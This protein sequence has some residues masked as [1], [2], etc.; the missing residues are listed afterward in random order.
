MPVRLQCPNPDCQASFSVLEGDAPR[1][2]RCPQCGWEL[3]GLGT[4]EPNL[5]GSADSPRS[6]SNARAFAGLTAGSTFAVRYEIVKQL[7]RGGMGVVYL[8]KDT[9][10]DREVALKIPFVWDDEDPEFLQRFNREARAAARLHHPNICPIFDVG[11]HDGQPYL[12]MAYL[13]GVL[14]SSYIKQR[15]GPLEPRDAIRLVRKLAKALSAAHQKGVIHRDLKPSNIMIDREIGPI[16]MDFGLARREDLEETLRTRAGH[17]LGTPAYMPIEQFQGKIEAVGPRSDVYSL[18]VILF[19]LLTGR[20]PYEG[21]AFEIHV[22][23]LRTGPPSPS[24]FRTEL[25]PGLDAVCLKAMAREPEDRYAS[26]AEF[27]VALVGAMQMGRS[28]SASSVKDGLDP[29]GELDAA[30]NALTPHR[31]EQGSSPQN[32]IL[33]TLPEPSI[34][35]GDEP[36]SSEP[37]A[38][39]P[40]RAAEPLSVDRD[41]VWIPSTRPAEPLSVDRD[42]VWVPTG[43]QPT[44]VLP[45]IL[46]RFKLRHAVGLGIVVALFSFVASV[47]YMTPGQNLPPGVSIP[48]RRP[49]QSDPA[50]RIGPQAKSVA[51]DQDIVRSRLRQGE[52]YLK[53]GQYDRALGEFDAVARLDPKSA[54][55][56][57]N[58]GIARTALNDYSHAMVDF[59]EAIRLDPKLAPAYASRGRVHLAYAHPDEA[60]AD[61]EQAQKLDSTVSV[62]DDVILVPAYIKRGNVFLG[63]R[64]WDLAIAAFDRATALS[65]ND[66]RVE[67]GRGQAY[68]SQ[69]ADA[70]A[71]RGE[72]SGLQGRLRPAIADFSEALSLQP[73][74]LKALNGRGLANYYVGEFDLAITDANAALSTKPDCVEALLVRAASRQEKGRVDQAI[75]DCGRAL[76]LQPRSLLARLVRREAHRSKG[77]LDK[78][79]ADAEDSLSLDPQTLVEL[80]YRSLCLATRNEVDRALGDIDK[81]LQICPDYVVALGNRADFYRIKGDLE[82]AVLDAEKAIKL[83]PS[84]PRL[85]LIRGQIRRAKGEIAQAI[86]DEEKAQSIYNASG[87]RSLSESGRAHNEKG[88]YDRAVKVLDEAIRID[89][90]YATAYN[91]R[92]NAYFGK[93][94]FASAISD[95]SEAIR[96]N[97]T[98]AV[99]YRNRGEA[100]HET[101]TYDR[102]IADFGQAIKLDP[103]DARAYYGRGAAYYSKQDYDLAIA[104]FDNAIR[105]DP[106]YVSAHNV[107]GNSFD[108]RKDYPR[109]IADYTQAIKLKPGDAVLY[110]NR[111]DTYVKMEKFDLA[112]ADSDEAIRL[113]PKFALAYNDRG[114]AYEAKK[115]YD[116]AI[117]AR[118][119]AIQLMPQNAL[120][121]RNRGE[122]YFRAGRNPE[123]LDDAEEAIR[124][125]PKHALAYNLRGV[126]YYDKSDFARAIADYDQAINLMPGHA[127]LYRNRGAAYEKMGN[128]EAAKADFAEADRLEHK[129]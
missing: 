110:R 52:N 10:L 92:G 106:K 51:V 54:A 104:D 100:Y 9:R 16:L 3:S 114:N 45:A 63:Q 6:D 11:D 14:L 97:P 65:P 89:P 38:I 56:F 15:Q 115:E 18:G 77:D 74:H 46:R 122:T 40:E 87:P 69:K 17:Q 86:S 62:P 126:V 37:E 64:Q 4:A 49:S 19:E 8:A 98:D 39:L 78:A 81:A 103:K 111:G 32:P 94:D 88:E 125:D 21:N 24:S 44:G 25:D 1:F 127:L 82:Q 26:M 70:L 59:D 47:S 57:C 128:A 60:L 7:G 84:V 58:R 66:P 22:K 67:P 95:F 99:V 116:R 83:N 93:N 118:S 35:P 28:N 90:T 113:D 109:A 79:D 73:T 30:A 124:I 20:R 2:R 120:F 68:R 61:Y 48:P 102:A 117:A 31:T 129:H 27:D 36:H 33:F 23:L 121:R 96:L 108:A 29:T 105:L 41:S 42:S 5:P 75:D 50:K 91:N 76:E 12:T 123:A 85:Y 55:A 112:I 71:D 107:R 72:T 53:R 43:P 80:N 101:A 119:Q 34:A 13:D